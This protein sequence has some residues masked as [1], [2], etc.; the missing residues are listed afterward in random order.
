MGPEVPNTHTK[1]SWECEQGHRWQ[2]PYNAI[3]RGTGCPVCASRVPKT[4][5]DYHAL[6]EKRGFRWLGPEVPNTGTRTGW[7]CEQGHRWQAPYLN[8]RR[9]RG[10]P[11]CAGLAPKMPADYHTLAEERGFRWL[12]PEASTIHTKT[13]WECEQ[14]HHWQAPYHNIRRGSGCPFCARGGDPEFQ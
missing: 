7:E 9:G 3:R 11:F 10:C 5:T 13:E 6:A 8:I 2:A 14:G 1:T 12:G 4:I